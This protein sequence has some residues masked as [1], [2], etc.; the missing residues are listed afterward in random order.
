MRVVL[1]AAVILLA[2]CADAPREHQGVWVLR[3]MEAPTSAAD[4]AAVPESDRVCFRKVGSW[5][6]DAPLAAP[7]AFAI[8]RDSLLE[9][10]V[11][12]FRLGG[13]E[14]ARSIATGN[15]NHVAYG[16]YR[17]GH[18]AIVV[19]DPARRGHLV[20]FSSQSFKGPNTDEGLDLLAGHRWDVYRLDRRDRI[21]TARLDEFVRVARE[22]AGHWYGYDFIGMFGIANAELHPDTP[23][24]V[25]RWYICSTVV[26]AA[27]H[28]A[29]VRLDCDR[30]HGVGD[31]VTPAQ[32]VASRGRIVPPPQ[33]R[34]VAEHR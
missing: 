9:G 4:L 24:E 7:D 27:L 22:K 11:L 31:L 32:V 28:Y 17:Y 6:P 5:D 25:G 23:A 19:K 1:L 3:W 13:A 21:D 8:A 10:D 2:A 34:L 18:L 20:Q 29:G 12:A 26:L 33:V 30:N 15:L 16:L 14:A